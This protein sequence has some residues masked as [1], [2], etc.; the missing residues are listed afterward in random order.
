MVEASL[1]YLK[2]FKESYCQYIIYML[3]SFINLTEYDNGIYPIIGTGLV[4]Q[5][6]KLLKKD[7][8]NNFK[9]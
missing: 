1:K 9:N 6:S 7:K 5:L 4:K 2:N 3:E 8:A